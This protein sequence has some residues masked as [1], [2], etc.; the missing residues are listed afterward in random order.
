MKYYTLLTMVLA[1]HKG[2]GIV[3]N[4]SR[5]EVMAV[6]W[7][8]VIYFQSSPGGAIERWWLKLKFHTKPLPSLSYLNLRTIAP[9]D[10]D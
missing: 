3:C 5:S 4:S 2:F 6:S 10:D 1:F 7:K 9:P 8:I